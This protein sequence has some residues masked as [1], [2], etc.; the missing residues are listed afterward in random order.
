[1]KIIYLHQYFNTPDMPGGTRSYEM[2]RRL[3]AYGHQ[4]EMVTSWREEDGKSAWFTTQESGISVHWLPVPY[5]NKMGFAQRLAAFHKFALRAALKA[6]QLRGDVIFATSTPLTIAIPAIIASKFRKIPMVFE[7]RDL[8]P[9]LP[10]VIGALK[11]PLLKLGAKLLEKMAYLNAERVVALSPGMLEG[12]VKTGYPRKRV[13]MI[14]N[15][16]DIDLFRPD[17][18]QSKEFRQKYEWLKDRPLVI[19][20]GTMGEI[21]GV[22]YLAKLAKEMLLINPEVR[23]LIVGQGKMEQLV[24]KEAEK[25]GVLDRNFFMMQQLPKNQIPN[26]FAAATLSASTFIDLPEMWSNSAN[27]FFDALACGTP[28]I[29]NYQGWQAELLKET[30]AGL[31]VDV[32]SPKSAAIELNLKIYDS[33]WLTQASKAA[34]KLATDRFSRDKLARELEEVL[35]SSE[36]CFCGE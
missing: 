28:V 32:K 26:V 36:K 1:M 17:L 2:A 10:I 19:Y 31:V 21:N 4:V 20:C 9:E 23:F 33:Y 22:E 18:I 25:L 5:S 24:K 27:K 11:N 34:L 12:I 6:I 15:S 14:P 29:I 30:G 13:S 3:V 16:S 7:V 35:L 8:W